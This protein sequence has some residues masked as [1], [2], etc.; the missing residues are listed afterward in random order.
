MAQS[1]TVAVPCTDFVSV[2]KNSTTAASVSFRML[3]KKKGSSARPHIMIEQYGNDVLEVSAQN[4]VY[5]EIL[6]RIGLK[7]Y[8]ST[9]E[10]CRPGEKRRTRMTLLFD[11]DSKWCSPHKRG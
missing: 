2:P 7:A 9:S 4:A 5:N 10:Y 1:V 3:P 8:L 6:A 11:Q